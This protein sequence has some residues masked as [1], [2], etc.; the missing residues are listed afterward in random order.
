MSGKIEG[1]VKSVGKKEVFASESKMG[2]KET[3]EYRPKWI[4]VMG[5]NDIF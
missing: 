5:F 2:E 1:K 3:H 4:I